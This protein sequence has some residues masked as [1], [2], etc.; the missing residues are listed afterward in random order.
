MRIHVTSVSVDDQGFALNWSGPGLQPAATRL[1]AFRFGAGGYSRA[2]L[3]Q[4]GPD[5][6]RGILFSELERHPG[7][8]AERSDRLAP[9]HELP[10][11]SSP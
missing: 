8:G 4:R 2:S 11:A 5:R 6:I 3:V 10:G 7:L 9:S 1:N